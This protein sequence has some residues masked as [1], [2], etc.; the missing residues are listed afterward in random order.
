MLKNKTVLKI[1]SLLIA[2]GLWMYVTGSIN[3]TT[4]QTVENIPVEL[5]NQ[6]TLEDRG[7]AIWEEAGFSVNVVLEGNRSVL[8]Q[9]DKDEIRATADLFGYEEGESSVPVQVTVPDNT[10][11]KEVKPARIS[12]TVDKLVSINKKV[13]VKFIGK[14]PDGTDPKAIEMSPIEV[15]VKGAKKLIDTIKTVQ[16]EINAAQLTDSP[17]SFQQDL[18]VLN[19][20]GDQVYDVT[21]SAE[22]VEVDAAL[23]YTKTVP[24][25]VKTKGALPQKYEMEAWSA[26]KKI[27]ICGLK[28]VLDSINRVET[29]PVNLSKIKEDTTVKLKPALPSGAELAKGSKRPEVEIKIKR[30]TE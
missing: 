20:D 18:Q 30:S 17:K 15:E 27:K 29:S 28:E 13:S 21:L 22:T 3:P 8:N 9:M 4:R 16:V 1:L 25:E 19:E 10:R 26:T 11:L 6:D 12:V 23:Y 5:L 24:L 2:I 7:L 14:A